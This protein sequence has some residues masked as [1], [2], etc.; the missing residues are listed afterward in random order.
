MVGIS[1]SSARLHTTPSCPTSR[2]ITCALFDFVLSGS[3]D[4]PP[5]SLVTFLPVA[6]AG[7]KRWLVALRPHAS[8]VNGVIRGR[9]ASELLVGKI[10]RFEEHSNTPTRGAAAHVS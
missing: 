9:L 3:V 4:G 1:S 10:P 7:L 6:L 2:P 8:S 5:I